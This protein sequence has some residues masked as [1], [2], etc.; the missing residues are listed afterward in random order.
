APIVLHHF[1][2]PP[3]NIKQQNATLLTYSY[4]DRWDPKVD[5][6][7]A[8]PDVLALFSF[9]DAAEELEFKVAD[10]GSIVTR[11]EENGSRNADAMKAQE[12]LIFASDDVRPGASGS[13][14]LDKSGR[15]IG[16]VSGGSKV[17]YPGLPALN[18][19]IDSTDIAK[20]LRAHAVQIEMDA[21]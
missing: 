20:F 14:I 13:P 11:T 21:S 10:D 5:M 7:I 3:T 4:R 12:E 15:V 1:G 9:G 18:F 16:L 8:K 19:A 2:T 17:N 6:T